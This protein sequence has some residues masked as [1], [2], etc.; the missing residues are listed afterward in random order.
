LEWCGPGKGKQ[1]EIQGNERWKAAT[2]E[3]AERQIAASDPE[4]PEGVF[5]QGGRYRDTTEQAARMRQ[6]GR[7]RERERESERQ[8]EQIL[9]FPSLKA[10]EGE[11]A[12]AR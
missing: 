1:R 6:R 8:R 3:T 5:K 4:K 12:A 11:R 7:E 2:E 10:R 9:Q